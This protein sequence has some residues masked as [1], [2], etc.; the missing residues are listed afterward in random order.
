[1]FSAFFGLLE[2]FKIRPAAACFA[3]GNRRGANLELGNGVDFPVC[4]SNGRWFAD[5]L[6]VDQCPAGYPDEDRCF[7]KFL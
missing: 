7:L 1:M 2:V 4:G 3:I 6:S 5:V